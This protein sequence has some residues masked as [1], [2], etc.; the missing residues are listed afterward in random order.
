MF[1]KNPF[2]NL[3]VFYQQMY[4]HEFKAYHSISLISIDIIFHITT[5]I[6][7]KK[8]T[9]LSKRAI[10]KKLETSRPT[11][12]YIIINNNVIIIPNYHTIAVGLLNE[13]CKI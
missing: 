1:L 6:W 10:E 4:M 2:L 13:C 7:H 5:I 3:V 12:R 9:I 8:T 11:K